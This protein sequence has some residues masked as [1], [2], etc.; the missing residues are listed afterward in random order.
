MRSSF[1]QRA[2]LL[3]GIICFGVTAAR[4]SDSR[5]A[6]PGFATPPSASAQ[7]KQTAQ[8]S[9][10]PASSRVVVRGRVGVSIPVT[11]NRLGVTHYSSSAPFPVTAMGRQV[12]GSLPHTRKFG[13]GTVIIGAQREGITHAGKT[14]PFGAEV[15]TRRTGWA[16]S[17]LTTLH[18]PGRIWAG[19]RRAQ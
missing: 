10:L 2:T 7:A 9:R 16:N 8:P 5:P 14:F 12:D 13:D 4:G 1:V 18:S 15:G 19:F 11:G 17:G 6:R 3:A